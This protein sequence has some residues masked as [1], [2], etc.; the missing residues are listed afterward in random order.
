MTK[1]FETVKHDT[2]YC[3]LSVSNCQYVV[4]GLCLI[5]KRIIGK[6]ILVLVFVSSPHTHAFMD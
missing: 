1:R 6:R 3:D 4:D 2:V 5:M